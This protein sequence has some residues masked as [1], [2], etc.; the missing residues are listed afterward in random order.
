MPHSSASSS[1]LIWR[2]CSSE[3]NGR[4]ERVLEAQHLLARPAG[5]VEQAA[6]EVEVEAVGLQLLDELEPRDVVGAVVARAPAHLGRRQQPARLVRA[7]VAH[8]HPD[9]P[10]ELVDRQ[11]VVV[12]AATA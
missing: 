7:D 4:A 11:L 8:G 10:R 9:P 12:F 5:A 2:G 3:P 1:R 6:D